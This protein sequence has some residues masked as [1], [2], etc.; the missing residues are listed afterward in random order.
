LAQAPAPPLVSSSAAAMA[1]MGAVDE[2]QVLLHGLWTA[3]TGTP[4]AVLRLSSSRPDFWRDLQ[5]FSMFAIAM[6]IFNWG[7]RNFV[8]EPMGK[9]SLNLTDKMKQKFGQSTMEVIFYGGFTVIGAIVV[10]RQEWIWP[11]S[12]WWIGFKSTGGHEVM[13]ADLR[14]YYLMYA[15]RYF[16]GGISVFLEHTRKD[17][18]EMQIHHWTTVV[19][20]YVSYFYGWNRVGCCV[21]LLLDPAD[22][23]LHIAKMC[24]YTSDSMTKEM[25]RKALWQ[26]GADVFFA[27]FAVVFFVTRLV[28]YPYICWSAH[29]ESSRIWGVV[30]SGGIWGHLETHDIPE[31]TCVALLE[32]LLVLQCFWFYLLV[33]AVVRMFSSGGIED[34]RS[35]DESE[36]DTPKAQDTK[37]TS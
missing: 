10:P 36:E 33:R 14:C 30:S 29:I 35:D 22:A 3:A 12:L 25:P 5:V 9:L 6:F 13:R 4:E 19:L 27:I 34:V 32:I 28:V 18:L 11:S 24:K 17:F 21:M 15:A 20:I 23:I 2:I 26:S 37:K 7:A 8:I 16:Q 31:W 1:A